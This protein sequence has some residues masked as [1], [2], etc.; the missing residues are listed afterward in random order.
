MRQLRTA[1]IRT[2][3]RGDENVHPDRYK[4]NFFND[5]CL[6]PFIDIFCH[7]QSII[8]NNKHVLW[9]FFHQCW[10]LNLGLDFYV[11]Q[12]ASLYLDLGEPTVI[13]NETKAFAFILSSNL[14]IFLFLA[15]IVKIYICVS[16]EKKMSN[17]PR[18]KKEYCIYQIK[19]KLWY[20]ICP[21]FPKVSIH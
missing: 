20:E 19:K 1:R 6:N 7:L 18:G 9:N 4:N 11:H 3:S 8:K 16:L 10:D 14:S 17:C 2:A 15:K 5:F 13:T 21:F 12:E